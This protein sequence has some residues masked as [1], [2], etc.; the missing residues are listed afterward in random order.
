VPAPPRPY[1][2][3]LSAVLLLVRVRENIS[4]AD[5][6]VPNVKSY[7]R[8]YCSVIPRFVRGAQGDTT[9]H[10]VVG[11]SAQSFV[12]QYI[13]YDTPPSRTLL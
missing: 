7:E 4:V 8:G 11:W 1:P 10:D 6:L 9:A 2:G 13:R 12:K 3:Y 5:D